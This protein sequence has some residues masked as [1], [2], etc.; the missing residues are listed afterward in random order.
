[1]PEAATAGGGV[2]FGLD[3]LLLSSGLLIA[4]YAALL[5][6]KIH[7]T[8]AALLG[9]GLVVILGLL[10]QDQA[11][12]AIDF[13]TIALLTGM[14][15][16]VS[17][18]RRTGVF[19]FV[20]IWAAKR[21][22]AEPRAVL[23]VLALVTAVFSA[24]LDNLTTVLLIVPIAMLIADKLKVS[25]TPFLISQILAAN[26]GGTA[27]LIGDP[28]NIMIGSAVGLTFSDFLIELG[29]LIAIVLAATFCVLFL[30]WRKSLTAE[31]R[32]RAR[33]MGFREA[34]SITDGRLLIRCLAVLAA[35]IAG[36]IV[37]EHH[38]IRPG[39]TAIFGAAVL[40]LLSGGG[41][42]S[43]TRSRRLRET[44]DDV[45]WPALFFF[46]GLFVVVG[47]VEHAGVLELLGHQLMA[48]TEGNVAATTF[49]VLWLAAMVSAA[50]DNIPFVAT[51]IPLVD[52][53]T[54]A[55]GGAEAVRPVWWALAVGACLGGNGTLIGAAANVMVAGLG[56]RANT[57][58]TFRRYLAY[59][60]PLMILSI[61]IA[62]VYFYLV[63]F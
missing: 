46:M 26:I 7:R 45:E 14:M 31:K 22:R 63:N 43:K 50:L 1:M 38:G 57:P 17:I 10:T 6:E 32:D 53:M 23:L 21:V 24:F 61:A 40:M 18:T 36:F 27:T 20:A 25:P 33:V 35:V 56:E 49:S 58:L 9:T 37:G 55:L 12:A 29:P 59:G 41:A 42:D 2:I 19:E 51:M 16:I 15:I 5:S 48:A 47:A 62:T 52:S 8:I 30:L 34:E 60:L 39:T 44:F 54:P 28:P 13:N 4:T 3:P 11:V